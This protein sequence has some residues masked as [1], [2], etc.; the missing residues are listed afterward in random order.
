MALK[1]L[2]SLEET[3]RDA[4]HFGEMG[5]G[6]AGKCNEMNGRGVATE[7]PKTTYRVSR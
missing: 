4:S 1:G 6:I 5:F 2:L 7:T 3:T